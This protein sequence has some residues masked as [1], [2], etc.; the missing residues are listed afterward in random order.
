[1]TALEVGDVVTFC[2]DW[3]L[4]RR[5]PVPSIEQRSR[6]TVRVTGTNRVLVDVPDKDGQLWWQLVPTDWL[7]KLTEEEPNEEADADSLP[8]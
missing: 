2:D 7:V 6:F 1:M 3:F 8:S 5:M 4:R